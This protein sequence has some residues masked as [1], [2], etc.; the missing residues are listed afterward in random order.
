MKIAIYPGSFDPIT[1]GHAD[2]VKRAACVFDKVIVAVSVNSQKTSL[3]SIEERIEL[4]KTV[5]SDYENVQVDTF[6]GLLVDYA[7]KV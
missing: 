5:F 1:N 2:I 7:Q 6:T 4:A 3:F